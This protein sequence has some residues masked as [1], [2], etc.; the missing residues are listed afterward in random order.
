[1]AGT[2]TLRS[3]PNLARFD[4]QREPAGLLPITIARRRHLRVTGTLGVLRA[5]AEHGVV[6]VGKLLMR[7][8]ATTFYVDEA[9]VNSIFER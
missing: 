7:P 5:G 9:L 3:A 8:S 4:V 1:L 2:P 6:N